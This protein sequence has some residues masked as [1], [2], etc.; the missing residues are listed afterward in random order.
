MLDSRDE[1]GRRARAARREIYS[2]D[3]DPAA[4]GRLAT[5]HGADVD[6]V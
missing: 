5:T 1:Y 4:L 6:F 2:L 3:E